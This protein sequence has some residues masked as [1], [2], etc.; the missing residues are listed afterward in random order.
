MSQFSIVNL[1]KSVIFCLTMRKITSAMCVIRVSSFSHTHNH[2]QNRLCA[3]W[4]HKSNLFSIM[5]LFNSIITFA[6][7]NKKM[8]KRRTHLFLHFL[9]Q[10]SPG[11][12]WLSYSRSHILLISMVGLCVF[13]YV[14]VSEC[15]QSILN[16]T[17]N[18]FIQPSG[19]YFG[20]E[21]IRT[22][23]AHIRTHT[24]LCE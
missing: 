13:L 2:I 22:P 5:G 3:T 17:I 1:T 7:F 24:V 12:C 18:I 9:F 11:L 20:F 19:C 15:E 23:T 10:C 16:Y 14:Q 21:M 6:N 4:Y 8:S